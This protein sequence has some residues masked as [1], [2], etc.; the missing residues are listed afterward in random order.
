MIMRRSLTN[1]VV[2]G[3]TYGN[4]RGSTI[5]NVCRIFID[6]IRHIFA[7]MERVGCFMFYAKK[8]QMERFCN[9]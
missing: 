9:I 7:V 6:E 3:E 5:Y 2:A 1:V 8:T 4:K